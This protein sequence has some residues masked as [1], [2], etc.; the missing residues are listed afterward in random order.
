MISY[1]SVIDH[2][3]MSRIYG[4]TFAIN[5][6]VLSNQIITYQLTRLVIQGNPPSVSNG[7]YWPCACANPDTQPV[8]LINTSNF[9]RIPQPP[10]SALSTV[11][12]KNFSRVSHNP[13]RKILPR[14]RSTR[15]IILNLTRTIANVITG[16]KGKE[17]PW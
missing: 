13:S 15:P 2:L 9:S 4:V 10:S 14:F 8:R 6:V 11:S 3:P 5:Q 17:E 1:K 16:L 7:Y 12:W